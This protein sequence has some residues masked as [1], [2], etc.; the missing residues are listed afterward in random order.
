MT[1]NYQEITEFTKEFHDDLRELCK[2]YGILE[3]SGNHDDIIVIKCAD[4]D[5]YIDPWTVFVGIPGSRAHAYEQEHGKLYPYR[6]P[7]CN[8]QQMAEGVCASCLSDDITE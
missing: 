4:S 8:I 5:Y 6:C 3:M 7:V 1:R 2:K